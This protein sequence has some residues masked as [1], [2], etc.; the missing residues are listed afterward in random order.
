MTNGID[1][2]ESK[3]FC[4]NTS[5]IDCMTRDCTRCSN[6]VPTAVDTH[7]PHFFRHIFM[8]LHKTDQS[9]HI[10]HTTSE[11]GIIEAVGIRCSLSR[12][13]NHS[14]LRERFLC[15]LLVFTLLKQVD[16]CDRHTLSN[17]MLH[18]RRK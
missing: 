10:L 6:E 11:E 5:S 1:F 3:S 4:I 14:L 16:T 8:S 12:I 17:Q 18:C 2:S 9:Q 7:Q 15:A 13:R